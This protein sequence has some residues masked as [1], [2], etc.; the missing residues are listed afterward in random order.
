MIPMQ[1]IRTTTEKNP[2]KSLAP[3]DEGGPVEYI[4]LAPRMS[5]KQYMDLVDMNMEHMR[6]QFGP[7]WTKAKKF[8]DSYSNPLLAMVESRRH[9]I[10]EWFRLLEAD[11][12]IIDCVCKREGYDRQHLPGVITSITITLEGGKWGICLLIRGKP[13]QAIPKDDLKA[14]VQRLLSNEGDKKYRYPELR[15]HIEYYLRGR[16]YEVLDVQ[17]TV[18]IEV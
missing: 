6:K 15:Q 8:S 12:E 5:S 16:G 9:F 4:D 3:I 7:G 14:E 11:L 1:T 2:K 18:E 13:L 17:E 10:T